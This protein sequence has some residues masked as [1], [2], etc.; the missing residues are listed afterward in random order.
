[1]NAARAFEEVVE[2]GGQLSET[3]QALRQILGPSNMM[4]YLSMMAPRVEELRRVLKPTGSL[5]LHCDPTASH[6]L[7]MILDA[8]FGPRSFRNEV[9]WVR[10]NAR[11][12]KGRWPRVH[13]TLLFYSKS[14]AF[15]FHP[16]IVKADKAKLPH[17]LITGPDKKKY[18]TFEL[19]APGVTK[20]GDSGKPWRGFDVS[21][22]GRHWANTHA[23]ME[24]WDAAGLI[25]WAKDGGW[26]RRRD[27]K[28]FDP[29]A[30]EVTV[31]DVW[32]D[33]DRINQTAQERLGY[34]TQK[35][36]ALL[37]RILDASA[38]PGDVVLDPF[39]GCGTTISVAEQMGLSWI[40][41][42][43]THLAIGLIK[44]RLQDQFGASVSS[45][46]KVIGEPVSIP[47]ANRLAIEDP[48]QFQAWALGLVGARTAQSSKKGADKGIDGNIYF[49]DD[50]KGKAKRI[51]LS[52]KAGANVNVSMVRDLVGTVTREKA[53]IGVLLTFTKPTKPMKDEAASAGFY[54]SP[55]GGMHEKVQILTVEELLDGKGI[56]YP[57]RSQRANTTFKRAPRAA[58]VVSAPTLFGSVVTG[59]D[60]HAG[61]D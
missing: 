27:D 15:T 40:G 31:G 55:M 17:T 2:E 56:D 24:G 44:H 11:S 60:E 22:M 10:H 43:I 14:E 33:V 21:A 59:T 6:Y 23:I 3:M 30:R 20:D 8:V 9:I 46:Y 52:V 58:P 26:P 48:F 4:A 7:K 38:N 54:K 16:V 42:D 50:Q 41:I 1:V 5:Y 36:E 53:D 25:H 29:E 35:P 57:T 19:T 39:C 51:I 32:T 34:P 12:T 45:H 61:S 18:Q 47:D 49:H 37:R 28:P 13:D